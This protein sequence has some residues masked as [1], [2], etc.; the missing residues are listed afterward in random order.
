MNFKFYL[1][2]ILL[3]FSSFFLQQSN[4]S[5]DVKP[6]VQVKEM[7]IPQRGPNEIFTD[8]LQVLSNDSLLSFWSGGCGH[9][10]IGRELTKICCFYDL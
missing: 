9:T 6:Y 5:E 8:C 1:N 3:L 2:V 7:V 10:G 4:N